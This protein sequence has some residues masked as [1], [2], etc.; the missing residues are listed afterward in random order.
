VR[1]EACATGGRACGSKELPLEPDDTSKLELDLDHITHTPIA[2][3]ATAT[4]R[5][6]RHAPAIAVCEV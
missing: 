1:I 5:A 3:L 6:R 4:E 2:D